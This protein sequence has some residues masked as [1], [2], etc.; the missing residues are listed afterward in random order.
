LIVAVRRILG[1]DQRWNVALVGAGNLGRALLGYRGFAQRGFHISAAF[2]TDATKV[3]TRIEGVRVYHFDSLAER[4]A[5]DRIRL[6]MIAV[7]SSAAQAVADRLAACGVEGVMNFAP[8]AIC[9]PAGVSQVGIDLAVELE[10]LAFSI[11]SRER[12]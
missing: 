8:L 3:G 1:T 12:T 11:L 4:V 9:L 5:R 7:P 2:D 10:Q 6:G